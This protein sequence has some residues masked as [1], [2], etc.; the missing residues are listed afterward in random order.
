[1]LLTVG[2][3]TR[4]RAPLLRQALDSLAQLSLPSP[5]TWE[6]LVVDNGSTDDTTA[7]VAER[8]GTLPL[9]SVFERSPGLSNARNRCVDE[10]RGAYLLWTDD[11][12]IVGRGWLA[13]YVRAF[14]EHPD[15]AVFGGPVR[16]SFEGVR[17]DWLAAI[18]RQVQSAYGIRDLGDALAPLAA[19]D[20]LPYGSNYAVRLIEQRAHRYDPRLGRNGDALLGG[21]EVE[22][23]GAIL[24]GGGAGWWIPGATVEHWIPRARQ[25]E[26]YLE[27]YYR[28]QGRVLA[29]HAPRAR[30]AS[31]LAPWGRPF[32]LWRQALE[33]ELAYRLPRSLRSP[34]HWAASLVRAST[35]WG[36]F[37]G[38]PTRGSDGPS[39]CG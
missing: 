23:L 26:R 9:R 30:D 37:A 13:E 21:E 17:P 24:R 15:A 19:P 20:R 31:A 36:L 2:I 12:V 33:A 1:M 7:V 27:R 38:W 32:W 5:L 10:A 16:P 22:V 28:A 4:N 34:E 35:T 18:W 11:D 29:L 3:C 14:G 39:P 8:S 6:V 25:T